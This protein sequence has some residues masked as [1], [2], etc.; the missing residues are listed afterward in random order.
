[1]TKKGFGTN[2][3]TVYKEKADLYHAFSASEFFTNDLKK[4]INSLLTGKVLLDV[5]CGTCHKTNIYSK[6][7]DKVYALDKSATLL[8]YAREKYQN[9]KK[10]N[11]IL[12]NADKIPL[13]DASVD[14][15]LITWGSFPLTKT[16][17]EIKRVLKKNGCIIRIGA[18]G[19]D[20]FTALF[21]AF[22]SR[23]IGTINNTFRKHS[24][25]ID[26]YNVNIRFD[27]LESAKEILGTITGTNPRK[28][29][30]RN[31]IHKIALCYYTKL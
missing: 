17:K 29:N 18:I 12:A 4:K 15:I 24:F 14:T 21:P 26:E 7:F 25:I 13:L 27:S 28:I 31:F 30:T 16:I 3:H 23:R 10:L 6:Y 2:F 20:D 8:S 22:S 1:M 5:A 19:L 9:N 11:Y